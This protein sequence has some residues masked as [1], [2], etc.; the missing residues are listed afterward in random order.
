[1]IRGAGTPDD[2]P[3][4]GHRAVAILESLY[5][6][7][8]LSTRQIHALHTP[9]AGLRF[10]QRTLAQLRI[11]GLAAKVRL[12]G[13][14]G[15]WYLTELGVEAVEAIPN[16]VETRRKPIPRVHAAG[17]LQTHTLEV[18]D[19]GI[20]FVRA[21]RAREDECGP[22]AWRHEIAHPLGPPPGRRRSEQL[23]ADAVLNYQLNDSDGPT[24]FH[25]R[26]V[27]LDRANRAADDLAARL[28]RYAKLY[29]HAEA[30]E[31]GDDTVPLWAH[32]YPVFPTVLVALSGRDR[33]ALERRRQM[34]LALCREEP[35]LDDNPEVEISV[36][37]LGDLVAE[38]PFA[39][40]F[41]TAADPDQPHDWL[42]RPT[43]GGGGSRS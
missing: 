17:S 22:F 41:R 1:M 42:S 2:V 34:V 13:G 29:R 14:L 15:V 31:P 39:P 12:P 18:N 9:H 43:V 26:F 36:C 27:E 37:L 24:T 32:S 10:A 33:E 11:T 20:A 38:G 35:A 25:Y 21:A 30:T 3:R 23:I 8:L 19:V 6:H 4:L 7:R 28:A 16:R 5:Q 40:I